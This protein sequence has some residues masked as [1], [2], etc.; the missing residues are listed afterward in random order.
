MDSKEQLKQLYEL[1]QELVIDIGFKAAKL[2]Y[3]NE[4]IK[5]LETNM[6]KLKCN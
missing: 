3:V 6:E 4:T 2:Q 1:R 5:Y